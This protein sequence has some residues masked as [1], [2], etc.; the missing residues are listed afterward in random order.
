LRVVPARYKCRPNDGCLGHRTDRERHHAFLEPGA[1]TRSTASRR[2]GQSTGPEPIRP[3]SASQMVRSDDCLIE[4]SAPVF[5]EGSSTWARSEPP[6]DFRTHGACCVSHGITWSSISSWTRSSDRSGCRR[7]APAHRYWPITAPATA[8]SRSPA[9]DWMTAP[10]ASPP[11]GSRAV[12]DGD[13]LAQISAAHSC[14]SAAPADPERPRSPGS[15]SHLG[16]YVRSLGGTQHRTQ[17]T[18]AALDE[19]L[20]S[21]VVGSRDWSRD[22]DA[23][24]GREPSA[25]LGEIEVRSSTPPPRRGW[26]S[27]P[28]RWP[29][30]SG[31]AS[32]CALPWVPRRCIDVPARDRQHHRSVRK[33][34]TAPVRLGG[35]P[36]SLT[37]IFSVECNHSA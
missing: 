15:V 23:P 17:L 27:P 26:G 12:A 1:S 5:I 22:G 14:A 9:R 33:P 16:R 36:P 20:V 28:P 6:P 32:S 30:P 13:Q 4:C 25:V 3:R 11:R 8:V 29:R 19:P 35:S 31:R 24:A 34:Q 21:H 7:S 10:A 2:G 37:A 18:A